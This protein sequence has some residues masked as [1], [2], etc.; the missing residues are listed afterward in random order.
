[1]PRVEPQHF[2]V[3]NPRT[4][5]PHFVDPR[6]MTFFCIGRGRLAIRFD[7]RAA[8]KNVSSGGIAIP[9]HEAFEIMA[10]SRLCLLIDDHSANRGACVIA[11][12]LSHAKNCE[13][14]YQPH[15]QDKI[16]HKSPL[17]ARFTSYCFR[18]LEAKR[19]KQEYEQ[20]NAPGAREY[21]APKRDDV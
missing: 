5:A 17:R 10:V 15:Q 1:M 11:L 2:N 16:S 20:T 8:E 13:C 21:Q 18:F 9:R 12:I 14:R 6:L 19:H 3:Q 4:P 7:S